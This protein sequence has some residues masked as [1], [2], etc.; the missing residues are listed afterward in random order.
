[1]ESPYNP[2]KRKPLGPRQRLAY[3]KPFKAAIE[4]AKVKLAADQKAKDEG[5][6]ALRRFAQPALIQRAG[7]HVLTSTAE[8]AVFGRAPDS[9]SAWRKFRK[10]LLGGEESI[11][12]ASGLSKVRGL[13]QKLRL[14]SKA[15][16]R[17]L[18]R[19]DKR[20]ADLE[21]ARSTLIAGAYER[22][23][24][25]TPDQL[26]ELVV[27]RKKLGARIGL[28]YIDEYAV[29]RAENALADAMKHDGTRTCECQPCSYARRDIERQK[30]Y[31]AENKARERAEAKERAELGTRTITCLDCQ[32]V[33]KDGQVQRDEFDNELF[34][35]CASCEAANYLVDQPDLP[36][37]QAPAP[38]QQEL[39]AA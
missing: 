38:G 14:M 27:K 33:T 39:V 17:A 24:K 29:T 12:I 15:D 36:P 16:A 3:L 2:H 37:D 9:P 28:G 8:L 5:A 13:V 6:A 22:G 31:A 10:A 32:E 7:G 25:V 11:S 18:A 30:R 1:M 21:A 4:A 20:I 26:V 34:V 19:L 23:V 35:E